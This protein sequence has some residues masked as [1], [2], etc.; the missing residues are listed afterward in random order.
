MSDQVERFDPDWDDEEME[1]WCEGRFVRYSD[2]R[3][4]V[5][6]L[7]AER[8][9]IASGKLPPEHSQIRAERAEAERDQALQVLAQYREGLEREIDRL[10]QYEANAGSEALHGELSEEDRRESEAKGIEVMARTTADRL[11]AALQAIPIPGEG[12]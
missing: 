4:V 9:K 2:H 10:R 7:E 12:A 5:E 8:D 11:Q 3:S 6:K 1:E